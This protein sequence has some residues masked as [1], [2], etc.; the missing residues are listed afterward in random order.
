MRSYIQPKVKNFS[1]DDFFFWT[2]KNNHRSGFLFSLSE[3]NIYNPASSIF[4]TK[5]VIHHFSSRFWQLL[6]S[7]A[8]WMTEIFDK[9]NTFNETHFFCAGTL[10]IDLSKN[11]NRSTPFLSSKSN[12][13]CAH[14]SIFT[15]FVEICGNFK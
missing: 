1:R 10:S 2:E 4:R 11:G 7:N 15:N 14:N 9:M 12:I 3:F 13:Q 5:F 6:K 8:R